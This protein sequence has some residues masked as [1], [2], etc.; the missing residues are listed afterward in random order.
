MADNVAITAGSGTTIGTEGTTI[1][2]VAVQVQQVKPVLGARDAYVAS[3]SGRDA[4][5]SGDGALFIDPR[6]LV[7]SIAVSPTIT[8][9]SAYAAGQCLGPLMSFAN[10]ARQ[11]GGSLLVASLNIVDA[12]KQ[13]AP[14]DLVLFGAAPTSTTDK[15]TFAPSKA[16][17]QKVVGVVPLGGYY[18]TFSTNSVASV[19]NVNLECIL[20]ATSTLTGQLVCRGTPTYTTTSSIVVTICVVQD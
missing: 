11:S 4:S 16:D 5:G 9:S 10:A 12:D 6:L 1:N 3:L 8:A 20:N 15:T 14:L 18:S 13:N 17:L 19:P 2:S 7:A